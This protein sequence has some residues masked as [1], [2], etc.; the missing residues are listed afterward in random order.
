MN[1]MNHGSVP[2]RPFSHETA[3]YTPTGHYSFLSQKPQH[4]CA[5]PT[6][7]QRDLQGNLGNSL[8]NVVTEKAS[9][10]D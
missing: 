9:G 3:V 1:W 10:D 2:C 7:Q 8:C 6:L 5:Y 4:T